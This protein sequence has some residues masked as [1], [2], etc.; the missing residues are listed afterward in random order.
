ME[1]NRQQIL[2]SF[3]ET[4]EGISDKEY[5]RRVWIRGEGPEVDDFDE[6]VCHFFQEGDNI[7][8]NYKDFR[9]TEN[10][11]ELLKK[12]QDNFKAFSDVNDWPQDFIDTLEWAKI[13][14]MAK[15]ILEAF[16]YPIS[17][18]KNLEGN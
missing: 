16:N 6:T 2:S 18:S 11:Y 1:I 12:F 10:Q 3:L 13:T 7:L 8:A 9:I 17:R 4:I 14:K 5:Q 15:E